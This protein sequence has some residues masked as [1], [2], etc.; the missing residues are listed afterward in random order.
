MGERQVKT[1]IREANDSK[2]IASVQETFDPMGRDSGRNLRVSSFFIPMT[3][4]K[5]LMNPLE[6]C[7]KGYKKCLKKC[8][9]LDRCRICPCFSRCCYALCSYPSLALETTNEEVE[10][11]RRT[12]VKPARR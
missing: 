4:E 7:F 12:G 11:L 3:K 5:V 8:C 9:H 2:P 10:I 6:G 1:G